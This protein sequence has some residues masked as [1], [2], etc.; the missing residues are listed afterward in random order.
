[1]NS[2]A[3]RY[4]HILACLCAVCLFITAPFTQAETEDLHP[5][6]PPPQRQPWRLEPI[7]RTWI[8]FYAPHD[9]STFMYTG[10][11]SALRL[12][13]PSR[14]EF[15]LFVH[16][17]TYAGYRMSAGGSGPRT[18]VDLLH[19]R[20]QE[21][22]GATYKARVPLYLY[23]LRDCNHQLDHLPGGPFLWSDVVA[24]A[25]TLPPFRHFFVK[26][27]TSRADA[28]SVVYRRRPKPPLGT[29][30]HLGFP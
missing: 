29:G 8:E 16:M 17:S 25:G 13:G 27:D 14:F 28:L 15:Y 23:L 3:Y 9:S 12:H 24:G 10:S 21:G 7:G 22:L 5:D 20:W 1:M 19:E 4:D 6:P 26:D 18:P 2:Y 11:E 30:Q